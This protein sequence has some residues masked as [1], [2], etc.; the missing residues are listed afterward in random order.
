MCSCRRPA[1]D[2]QTLAQQQHRFCVHH[3]DTSIDGSVCALRRRSHASGRVQ[4][5]PSCELV[6]QTEKAMETQEKD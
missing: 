5:L 4:L 2:D 3:T 6:K 1:G